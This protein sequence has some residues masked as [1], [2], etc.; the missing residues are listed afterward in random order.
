MQA[1]H[2]SQNLYAADVDVKVTA[3]QIKETGL[4]F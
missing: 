2:F 3:F 4:L 1:I